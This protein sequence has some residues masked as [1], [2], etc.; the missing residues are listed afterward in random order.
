MDFQVILT[1]RGMPCIIYDSYKY[2]KFRQTVTGDII[3]RCTKKSC[4]GAVRTNVEQTSILHIKDEHNHP[5]L[6]PLKIQELLLSVDN[7]TEY[8][9]IV[10]TAYPPNSKKLQVTCAI[11]EVPQAP[12]ATQKQSA[13]PQQPPPSQKMVPPQ[14]VSAPKQIAPKPTSTPV[15]PLQPLPPP[16]E[17]CLRWN[18]YHSNMQ[19]TFPSLLN[20]EQFV[21]VT[22]ACEGRSIKCH[23]MM[24]SACSAY[25]EELLSQNPCQHPIVLMKDLKYWEVQALVDFMYRGEVNVAQDKLPSLLAAAEALQ[26]KGL[27]G[28][29][30]SSHDDENTQSSAPLSSAEDYLDEST[31]SP[32]GSRRARKRRVMSSTQSP[33]TQAVQSPQVPVTPTRSTTG[34]RTVKPSLSMP[35]TSNYQHES[36]NLPSEPPARRARKS[37]SGELE[38]KIE[39]IDIE[40]SNDSMDQMDDSFMEKTFDDAEAGD[41][42]E[43]SGQGDDPGGTNESKPS[44]SSD[45]RMNVHGQDAEQ[46]D[47]G[48]NS[49]T[50]RNDQNFRYEDSGSQDGMSAVPELPG[51]SYQESLSQPSSSGINSSDNFDPDLSRSRLPFPDNFCETTAAFYNPHSQNLVQD[52]ADSFSFFLF[53]FFFS[54]ICDFWS[55][56][57]ERNICFNVDPICYLLLVFIFFNKLF[58]I[59]AIYSNASKTSIFFSSSLEYLFFVYL[60]FL[61][62][63]FCRS[64]VA[65]GL[66]HILVRI[67]WIILGIPATYPLV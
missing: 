40:I 21:D 51:T 50:S 57:T 2:R 32:S 10:H 53:F 23:K 27:A 42:G 28:P 9:D 64:L 20:N 56:D 30:F 54:L 59:F 11:S 38:I 31:P 35:S 24:L 5:R 17:V 60:D 67:K 44:I 52:I 18:S 63:P 61:W 34:K 37:E 33:R 62:H 58:F 8:K 36:S 4:L 25:F 48:N 39:P 29:A 22:L 19:A 41:G 47:F 43:S 7:V 46:M 45:T 65:N 66:S 49:G 1:S 15:S 12:P 3:W 14:Q 16:P 26:I 55:C 6:D 13:P